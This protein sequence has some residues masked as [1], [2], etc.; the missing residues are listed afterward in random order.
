MM[1]LS[2][3]TFTPA[4]PSVPHCL[5][6]LS[7]NINGGRAMTVPVTLHDQ[8]AVCFVHMCAGQPCQR[9]RQQATRRRTTWLRAVWGS[10]RCCETARSDLRLLHTVL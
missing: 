1:R 10:W 8:S 7:N 5:D 3:A 6:T 4:L 9:W 2:R